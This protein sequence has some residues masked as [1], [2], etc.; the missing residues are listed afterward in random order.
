MDPDATDRPGIVDDAAVSPKAAAKPPPDSYDRLPSSPASDDLDAADGDCGS[1]DRAEDGAETDDGESAVENAPE[2]PPGELPE[3]GTE[4]EAGAEAE[5]DECESLRTDVGEYVDTVVHTAAF[6][7]GV[8]SEHERVQSLIY[9]LVDKVKNRSDV[10][11]DVESDGARDVEFA[12]A[13][14]VSSEDP[15]ASGT[16]SAAAAPEGVPYGDQRAYCTVPGLDADPG[17]IHALFWTQSSETITLTVVLAV[18]PPPASARDVT[19]VFGSTSVTV[20]VRG[21]RILREDVAAGLDADSCLWSLD[22]SDSARPSLT[23]ELEKVDATWWPTLFKSHDPATYRLYQS[24][25]SAAAPSAATAAEMAGSLSNYDESRPSTSVPVPPAPQK[26]PY[27]P[28]A[29][30]PPPDVLPPTSDTESKTPAVPSASDIAAYG[31]PETPSSK[32]PPS[33][34]DLDDIISQYR[35]AFE[36]QEAGAAEA[37]LQLATFYHHGIGVERD[38]SEAAKLFR[39]ALENGVLDNLAAFQLG[40]IYNQGCEGLHADP[41]EAV[42]WW[43]VSAKLGNAVAMFNLGVMFMKG[44]GCTMDPGIAMQFFTQAHAINPKL[45]P[46]EFTPVQLAE[47]VAQASRLKKLRQKAE[48]TDEERQRRHDQ[49]M[50]TLRYTMYGTAFVL[51]TTVSAVLL[52]IWW[53]NRL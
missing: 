16:A 30:A 5:V 23:L 24:T 13:R 17:R 33:R 51:G 44:S 6:T 43:L 27:S 35:T 34:E 28:T 9:N 21:A 11:G 20:V 19:V 8:K 1:L 49:A 31:T 37:A 25:S 15:S 47:R 10:A 38:V 32:S 42:R 50:E 53:K 36:A 39:F 12:G 40:L 48:L 26:E 2:E 41:K 22:R 29:E 52:R 7:A 14:A 3:A 45:R 46:P 18:A 4:A